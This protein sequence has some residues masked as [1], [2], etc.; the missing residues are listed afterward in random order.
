MEMWEHR[1][2]A[3]VTLKQRN[4]GQ[5]PI[6]SDVSAKILRMHKFDQMNE[7]QTDGWRSMSASTSPK[8]M[9]IQFYFFFKMDCNSKGTKSLKVCL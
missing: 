3:P 2:D 5:L 9:G 1:G 8:I 6:I 4:E 7:Q